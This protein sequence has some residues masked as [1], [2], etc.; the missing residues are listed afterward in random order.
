MAKPTDQEISA[1][2]RIFY[3]TKSQEM[4]PHHSMREPHRKA[5]KLVRRWEVEMAGDLGKS[6]YCGFRRKEQASHSK[7]V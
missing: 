6:L 4:G 1:I 7:Q 2:E 5:P 3:Y